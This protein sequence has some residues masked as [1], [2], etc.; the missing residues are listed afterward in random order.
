ML[1]LFFSCNVIADKL[2]SSARA[3]EKAEKLGL[4]CGEWFERFMVWGRK[5][6]QTKEPI[7]A[8]AAAV[9]PKLTKSDKIH[10]LQREQLF[11]S[12]W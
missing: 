2:A 1:L 10:F 9:A 8:E 5:G 7:R 4:L 6:S 3:A 12:V 11:N